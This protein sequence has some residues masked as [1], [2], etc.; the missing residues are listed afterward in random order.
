MNW[1]E[2]KK[3]PPAKKANDTMVT[4]LNC[5][6]SKTKPDTDVDILTEITTIV[7]PSGKMSIHFCRFTVLL[8]DQGSLSLLSLV[9]LI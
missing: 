6:R 3:V 1:L 9:R 2:T 8:R 4:L 7:N 5:V